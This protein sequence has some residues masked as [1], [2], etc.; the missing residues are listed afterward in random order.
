MTNK[1]KISFSRKIKFIQIAIKK[2]GGILILLSF[3]LF[4][5]IAMI[6][7]SYRAGVLLMV[8]FGIFVTGM[9]LFTIV[10]TIPSSIMYYYEKE[11][12]KKYGAFTTAVITKKE[13]EDHSYI[14]DETKKK[15]EEVTYLIEY[16]FEYNYKHF[17]TFSIVENK[18]FY[19]QLTIGLDIPI[20]YLKT[21]PNKSSVRMRK[22]KNSLKKKE[23]A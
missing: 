14:D 21:N 1:L 9:A 12:I 4:L 16:T 15:V 19:D 10:Y 11:V 23:F 20:K 17:S 13:I 3:F 18:E 2:N 7:F 22:L 8:A 6:W 5:G